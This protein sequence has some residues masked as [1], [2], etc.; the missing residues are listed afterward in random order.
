MNKIKKKDIRSFSLKKLEIFFQSIGEEVFR[1]N[2]VYKWLWQ[3]GVP[4]FEK[5]TNIPK[6]LRVSLNENF[7]INN[8]LIYKQQKSKD[9]TIKN[10]V[11][12]HDGLIVESVIIPSKKRITA[13]VSSQVGCSL[14]CSFCA[15]SLLKRMRN[16][17]SD[18]IFDQ[19]VSISKQSKIYLNRPL[20]NIV[21]MGM[22]EPL[23]NYKNVIEA[24]KKITSND[25]LGLS[26]RRITLST[27][28]IPKMIKKLA[29]DR[30][31]FK[32]AVSLHSAR[33]SIREK[34]MPFSKNFPIEDLIESLKYW[35]NITNK[36]LTLEYIV[37]EGIN[38]KV[39]DINSLID[40]CKE[41]PSKVNLIQYNS[42][43]NLKFKRASKEKVIEYKNSLEE[44]KIPVSIRIS[45]GKD[46]DA[47]C[48]QLANK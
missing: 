29:D 14:D 12:L 38:D 44:V 18:E 47:A 20:T 41:V 9:G 37:W 32:L 46:I 43:G 33:Q 10:S 40:F 26:P 1:A 4:S 31:K 7:F 15:T 39:E 42:I 8:I 22:G 23:L 21:F 24:I 48:G 35:N 30:V 6:S 5:M 17:N 16:L 13:C 28:G 45:R 11:K 27:S 36:V 34:I 25:G 3:K 19:V 2:Q